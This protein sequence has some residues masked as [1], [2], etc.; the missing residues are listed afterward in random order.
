MSTAVSLGKQADIC[1]CANTVFTARRA[2][3]TAF[4]GEFM[5]GDNTKM[6]S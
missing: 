6:Y 5:G 4:Y 1:I 2:A 3:E